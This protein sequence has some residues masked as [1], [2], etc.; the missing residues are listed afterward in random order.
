MTDRTLNLKYKLIGDTKPPVVSRPGDA[1]FDLY[2]NEDVTIEPG[3]LKVISCGIC[4][5]LPEDAVGHIVLRTS[6]VMKGLVATDAL[7]DS[8]YRGEIHAFVYNL[9]KQ[10]VTYKKNDRMYSLLV[11]RTY[12]DKVNF[13][14]VEALSES[15]R[16]SSWNGSSGK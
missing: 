14:E 3:E 16:G 11:T 1:G 6:A 8:N 13:T 10:P 5:E 4:I 15:N 2:L 9:S 12:A 7:I